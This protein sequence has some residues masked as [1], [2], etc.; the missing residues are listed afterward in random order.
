M[1]YED[2]LDRA[3][4]QLDTLN[5]HAKKERYLEEVQDITGYYSTIT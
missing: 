3:S 2:D 1:L 4:V 5:V